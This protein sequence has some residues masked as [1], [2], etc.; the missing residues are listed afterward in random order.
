[1]SILIITC[2]LPRMEKKMI[3]A[4]VLLQAQFYDIDSMNV[5]WHGNYTRFYEEGRCALLNKLNY[6]YAE[7]QREGTSWPIATIKSKFIR[8]I[9]LHQSFYVRSLLIE[10][11]NRLKIRYVF[12]EK[13]SGRK[14]HTAETTQIAVDMKTGKTLFVTPRSL[15]ESV[16]REIAPLDDVREDK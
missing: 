1:M 4:D 11:E 10:W 8:P 13:E 16:E 3:Y 7:M 15:R 9:Y 6:N 5:V 12:T 2:T 14:I